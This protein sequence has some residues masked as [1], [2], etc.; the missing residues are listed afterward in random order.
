MAR[1]DPKSG[2]ADAH[3]GSGWDQEQG[4]QSKFGRYI[5]FR[6]VSVYGHDF[7]L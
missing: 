5:H 1:F 6:Y 2:I 4:M 7:T 3:Q